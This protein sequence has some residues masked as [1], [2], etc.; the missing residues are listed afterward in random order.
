MIVAE[1]REELQGAPEEWKELFRKHGLWMYLDKTEVMCVGKQVG[2]KHQ[3]GVKN[4]VH[5]GGNI[6]ENGRVEVRNR[7]GETGAG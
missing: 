1:H 6:S 7:I 3:A 4:C 2:A 5:L